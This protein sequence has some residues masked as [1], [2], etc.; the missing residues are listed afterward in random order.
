MRNAWLVLIVAALVFSV[1]PARVV[2]QEQPTLAIDWLHD[3]GGGNGTQDNPYEVQGPVARA[4]IWA[5]LTWPNNP[6]FHIDEV[7]IHIW[8]VGGGDTT[9]DWE[10]IAE[11]CQWQPVGQWFPWGVLTIKGTYCNTVAL[12]AD[13]VG[14]GVTGE[15]FGPIWSNELYFHVVPEPAAFTSLAGLLLGAGC[16]GWRRLRRR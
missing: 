13:L 14:S 12:K 10:W 7:S 11:H 8:H 5:N 2:A 1:L 4:L 6:E 16:I 3:R 15:Q 9:W